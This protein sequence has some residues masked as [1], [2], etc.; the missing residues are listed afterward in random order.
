MR[1]R[2][3]FGLIH[4]RRSH[5][6]RVI[7]LRTHAI[8]K[9]QRQIRSIKVFSCCVI[10]MTPL[11]QHAW[12]AVSRPNAIITNST[13]ALTAVTC[14]N[15]C[16]EKKRQL[17]TEVLLQSGAFL[18]VRFW[19]VLSHNSWFKKKQ[20]KNRN[21]WFETVSPPT[22]FLTTVYF[23]KHWI[24]RWAARNLKK[25]SCALLTCQ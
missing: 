12:N 15:V 19:K 8:I 11:T 5:T 7:R 22:H 18:W 17:K 10:L 9:Y 25:K 4:N 2:L 24:L 20:Q 1:T 16:C 14:R 3:P 6:L 21:G 23:Y 13:F